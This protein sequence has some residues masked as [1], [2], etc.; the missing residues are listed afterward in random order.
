MDRFPFT[1]TLLQIQIERLQCRTVVDI[2]AYEGNSCVPMASYHKK[3]KIHAVE[4]YSV[5][6]EMLR[7]K[8]VGMDNVTVHQLAISNVCQQVPL[9][10]PEGKAKTSASLFGASPNVVEVESQTLNVFQVKNRIDQIEVLLMNCEGAEFLI[11]DHPRSKTVIR[12]QVKI[13][14]LSLHGKDFAFLTEEYAQKK[15]N[16]NDF[17]V[18]CGMHLVY[19][20]RITDIERLGT[21]HIRQVWVRE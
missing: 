2:G 8:C 7:Q 16:I 13:L 3:M 19:G 10:M 20:E 9:V 6:C 18:D 5:N 14:D 11:F 12:N 4:P 17:L 1:K 21:G 15:K